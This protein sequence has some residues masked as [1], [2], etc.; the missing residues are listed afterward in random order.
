M[1]VD[2]LA[3]DD[4][5]EGDVGDLRDHDGFVAML[6]AVE[7]V[8][9]ASEDTDDERGQG[10]ARHGAGRPD[11]VHL[12][13]QPDEDVDERRDGTDHARGILFEHGKLQVGSS[14]KQFIIAKK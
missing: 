12:E 1:I 10:H 2:V 9:R 3:D 8:V 5:G 13:R 6:V 4:E 11:G 14:F 7:A